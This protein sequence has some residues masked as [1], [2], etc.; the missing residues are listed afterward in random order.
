MNELSVKNYLSEQLNFSPNDI[1]KL[2]IFKNELLSFNLKY[3]LISKKSEKDVWHR[4]ILDSAQLINFIDFKSDLSLS[5]LGTGGGFPG[6]VLAIFNKNSKFHVKL[7]E[8]S[9]IKCKFLSSLK[10]KISIEFSLYENDYQSHNIESSYIVCRAFKKLPKILEISRE[11][12]AKPHKL[13]I[14]KG[15]DAQENIKSAFKGHNHKYRL[16]NSITD[17]ESKIVIAE[18]VK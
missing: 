8:K 5:D 14:L 3:N 11:K 13:I 4:H 16:I 9:K 18:T 6:I 10:Q 15:K 7:Y 12:A 17:K 2:E 1:Q